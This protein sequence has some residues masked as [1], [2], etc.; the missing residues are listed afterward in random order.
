MKVKSFPD[1]FLW[2]GATS[3]NQC[4]GAYLTEGRKMSNVDIIPSGIK[5]MDVVTGNS[6]ISEY[7]PSMYYYPS[8]AAIDMYHHVEEDIKLFAEMGFKVYRFSISWSRIF[9]NGNEDIPNEKGLEFYDKIIALCL[10]YNIEP[11][12]TICHFDIPLALIE[13]YNGWKNRKTIDFYL[14]YCDVIFNRYKDKV[15]Y[16]IT[17]NEINMILHFPFMAA[18][19]NFKDNENK[20]QILYQAAHHELVASAKAVELL[21]KV[22]KTAMIGCMIAA[23][24]IYPRTCDPQDVWSSRIADRKSYMFVDVQARG[25]YPNY[26]LKEWERNGIRIQMD[27]DDRDILKNNLVDFVSL[28][29]Y[30]TNCSSAHPENFDDAQG[31]LLG[32]LQNPYVE[33]S[34]W[35]WAIDPL[36]F[37]ITLNDLYDRYQKPLFVVENGY[38]DV[39]VVEEDGS[40]HD[41]DRIK[42]LSDHIQAMKDA[43]NLDGVPIL[44]YTTWGCIDLVSAS[45][46]EFKKRYGFIYVDKYDDGTGSYKRMKKD[47][48]Y[49]YKKVIESN[50]KKI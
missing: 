5:R 1:G 20:E 44:G 48:F 6:K 21:H 50:G 45:S 25:E 39:D 17:F 31:N 47:S 42:Y 2:G 10:K 27:K 18:G 9:P 38:G 35:G 29:Y 36:G 13:K 23:G 33:K 34:K 26:I 46:G 22:D 16:W 7:D 41:L 3:A 43:I 30:D 8:H 11:L 37:R 12:I 4:E 19:I 15:K 14:H 40:I 24:A 49:W 32:N 28:S